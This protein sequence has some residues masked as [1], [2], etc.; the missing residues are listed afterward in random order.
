MKMVRFCVCVCV[1]F[2]ANTTTTTYMTKWAT[3][4]WFRCE[5]T[6]NDTSFPFHSISSAHGK[7]TS[8]SWKIYCATSFTL[9]WNQSWFCCWEPMIHVRGMVFPMRSV[10][11]LHIVR[12]I[13]ILFHTALVSGSR[14]TAVYILIL[15]FWICACILVAHDTRYDECV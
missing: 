1:D 13:Y 9:R 11:I 7:C 4:T 10:H 8:P 14:L 5:C 2:Y 3:Y 15:V 12:I 6:V